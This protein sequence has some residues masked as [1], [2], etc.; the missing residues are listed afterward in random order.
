MDTTPDAGYPR[1]DRDLRVDVAVV[2]GGI[3]GITAAA[4]LRRSGASVAVVE[5]GT[6]SGGVTG[7]TTAKVTSLHGLIYA[8]LRRKFGADGARAYAEANEAAIAR[9]DEFITELGI[10]CG[11]RRRA[12]YTYVES[13]EERRQVEDEVE[14]AR[15]IG[16]PVELVEETPLPYPVAAAVRLAD[17]A[18]FHPRA[19]LLALA[20]TIPGDGSHV[21]EH[22]RALG[23]SARGMPAVRTA[24]GTIQADHVIVATHMP[25]LD[26]GGYF[27]RLSPERSYAIGVR[28]KGAPP[29]GMFI[30]A[31]G[32][33]RSIRSHPLTGGELV[34]VGGEGHKTGEEPDT[35]SRY[36]RLEAFARERLDL[37]SI[38]Y[39]WST[40]DLMPADGL[41]MIGRLTPVSKRIFA[42][43][44]YRKWGMTNGTAAAEILAAEIQGLDSRFG[45]LF[46]PNRFTPLRSAR[47][48]VSENAKVAAHF[49]G[50]RLRSDYDSL[51]EL[52]P[53]DGGIVD[54]DAGA[55]A[56]HRDD[57]GAIH[58]VSPTCTH[59]GCRVKWN[60]A[61]RSWDCPCHG[62]RFA[63][64]G[65]VLQGPAV[66]PLAPVALPE[67][68]AA[69]GTP[70]G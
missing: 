27:A 26:R 69:A 49:V 8:E 39:R 14:A 5:A 44:G 53:G 30:S 50:D 24:G 3:T 52:A 45:A 46:S 68:E 48:V 62:S 9:I 4:L 31:D 34:I 55:V 64:D 42:A 70:A 20:E 43:T 19:Y 33:T 2:G 18:E 32:P 16:L 35:T 29:N 17:Q 51:A 15:D 21:F 56:A 6:V 1:L 63:A 12:A 13:S 65:A 54:T 61:E 47:G 60:T 7:F 57:A 38:D 22:T 23:V 25:F 41:P 11:W 40:Q 28:V 66:R 37:A 67:A 10:D 58:A 36:R 59:L